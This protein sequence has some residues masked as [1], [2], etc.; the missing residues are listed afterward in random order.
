MFGDLMSSKSLIYYAAKMYDMGS[1]QYKNLIPM[2]TSIVKYHVPEHAKEIIDQTITVFGGYGYFLE[3]EVERR[4]RDNRIV[5]MYEGTVEVQLNNIVRTL[6]T[7]NLD[8]FKEM[9]V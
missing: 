3:Q 8:F 6:K 7:V 5:E 2:F 9:L 4:Y 1:K